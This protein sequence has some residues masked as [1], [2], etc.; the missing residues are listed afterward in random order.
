[1]RLL[2]LTP[3]YPPM[4][5]GGERYAHA[6]AQ[7]AVQAGHRVTI[8]TSDGH[9]AS[10]FWTW[11]PARWQE[12]TT[13]SS[14][15]EIEV[16]RCPTVGMPGNRTGLLLWRKAMVVLSAVSAAS[17]GLLET[18]A[19]SVPALPALGTALKELGEVDLVHGFNLSWEHPLMAGWRYA[20]RHDLPFVVTPF[21]HFGTG[22]GDRVARNNTMVHQIAMLRDADAV[23][24]LT[25]V[26]RDGLVSL[27]LRPERALTVG[28]G[29]AKGLVAA[30][31]GA[32]PL[33][34]DDIGLGD[35]LVLFLGRVSG[36]KG[37][38]QAA[39]AVRL[40]A[41]GDH[42]VTLALAGPIQADFRRYYRGLDAQ[43][44]SYIRPLGTVDEQTKHALLARAKML[45]LPSRTDSFGMVFLEAWA[46]RTP[47]IGGRAG[48]IPGVI[49][50]GEDGL[51]V[52]I[53][54]SA[55]LAR[56]IHS[57]LTDPE[58]ATRMGEAGHQKVVR[59]YSWA[60]V[61]SRVA[62][63]YDALVRGADVAPGEFTGR[64]A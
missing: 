50:H 3:S 51:L 25:D 33:V 24:A 52:R 19:T 14:E 4:L 46:H 16:V 5:G 35:P 60:T 49:E 2:F 45:V 63:V 7:Q 27:G 62:G 54:Q 53:G 29:Y 23:L 18:M 58:T 39:E 37:A 36:D 17:S 11:R 55:E 48:G 21:A 9:R 61:Y 31:R 44:R 40:L 32:S 30:P 42:R 28:A 59:D 20:R 6:L 34:A 13:R 64:G 10:D 1:M 8:L 47:V 22:A 12:Q 15:E 43:S 56:A 38:M 41:D 57:L 26:E